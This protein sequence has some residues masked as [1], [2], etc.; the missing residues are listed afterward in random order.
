MKKFLLRNGN[1][2]KL[3]LEMKYKREVIE[4]LLR[5]G[6]LMSNFFY[7]TKKYS[8]PFDHPYNKTEM[9]KL[10]EE[11]NNATHAYFKSL[12]QKQLA[13]YEMEMFAFLPKS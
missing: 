8:L 2:F 1:L 5:V 3:E 11:W 6:N 13:K 7:N 12:S 4:E 10:Y 9:D